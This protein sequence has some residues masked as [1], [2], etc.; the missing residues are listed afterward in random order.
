VLVGAGQSLARGALGQ[1]CRQRGGEQVRHRQRRP[2]A[3][4]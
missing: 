4:A 2:G 1:P 3:G